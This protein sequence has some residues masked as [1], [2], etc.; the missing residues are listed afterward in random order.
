[1]NWNIPGA[2]S[3]GNKPRVLII[4]PAF[5][6]AR[7]LPKLIEQLE[8]LYPD[9]DIVVIDDGSTDETAEVVR[10]SRARLA[11]LPCNLGIGGA[12]QTGLLIARDEG[13]DIALQVDGDE[14]HPPDQVALL[15]DAILQ[16]GCDIVIGSRFLV[17]DG[18]Q[19]TRSRR[20][21]IKLFSAWLSAICHMRITDATSGFRAI[22]RRGIDLLSRDYAEDYPE[23][24]A[25]LVAHRA[26]LRIHEVPVQMSARSAGVSSIGGIR[27]LAY[28]AKVSLAILMWC[29]RRREVAD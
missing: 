7:S 15:A 8:S 25:I 20:L 11:S 4:I 24:E 13:Y 6:E 22:S 28:M 26:G 14:Q 1:V 27:S 19:S 3:H 17:R 16:T 23:V 2:R 5:N 10:N 21:G 29:I 18:Y 12:V 9:F